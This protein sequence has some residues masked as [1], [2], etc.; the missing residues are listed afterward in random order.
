MNAMFTQ[1]N[2]A[3]RGTL[4]HVKQMMQKRS[5]EKTVM[6]NFHHVEETVHGM[7]QGNIC[8]IAMDILGMKSSK[9]E[10]NSDVNL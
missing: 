8:L 4:Y 5:L 9:S 1:K 3:D 7:T 2:A 6:K 10:P